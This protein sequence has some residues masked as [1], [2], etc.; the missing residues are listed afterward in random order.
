MEAFLKRD[1]SIGTNKLSI[2]ELMERMFYFLDMTLEFAARLPRDKWGHQ[3]I[4]NRDRSL[5]YLLV[6]VLDAFIETVEVGGTDL[7]TIFTAPLPTEMDSTA[8]VEIYGKVV[9][10][11]IEMWWNSQEIDPT[12][13]VETFYGTQSIIDFAER[14]TWHC[15]QHVRQIDTVMVG[16]RVT[17]APF[18]D[19]G[20]YRGLP[21]PTSLWT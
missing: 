5:L 3:P 4:H 12:G 11:R 14:S 13:S 21:M 17:E 2:G 20:K 8:R 10:D 19:P 15:A 9:R 18:V 16:L 6:S 7:M 1:L